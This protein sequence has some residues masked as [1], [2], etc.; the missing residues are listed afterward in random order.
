MKI[1][2]ANDGSE[3]G[4]AAVRFAADLVGRDTAEF[5]IVSVIEPAAGT[6][7]EMVVESTEEII[8]AETPRISKLKE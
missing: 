8:D 3:F 5:K 2:I 1:L 7:L 4:E 6:E